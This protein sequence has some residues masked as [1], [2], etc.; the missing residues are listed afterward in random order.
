MLLILLNDASPER[1]APN[2]PAPTPEPV[3]PA[4]ENE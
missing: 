4:S 2:F 1:P 3:A